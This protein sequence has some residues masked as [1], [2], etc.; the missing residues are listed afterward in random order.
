MNYGN[1]GF[2]H[3]KMMEEKD[4]LSWHPYTIEDTHDFP[5]VSGN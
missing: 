4:A 5:Y 1:N 3:Q 2:M